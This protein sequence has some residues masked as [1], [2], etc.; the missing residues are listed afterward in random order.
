MIMMLF[1][2]VKFI[3]SYNEPHKRRKLRTNDK[4]LNNKNNLKVLQHLSGDIRGQCD[5][6]F[7]K[8]EIDAGPKP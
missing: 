6:R 4:K 2:D 7:K 8:F 3:V 1:I 5:H